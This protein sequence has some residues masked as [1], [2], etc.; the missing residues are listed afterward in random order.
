MLKKFY[1]RMKLIKNQGQGAVTILR[2]GG[3]FILKFCFVVIMRGKPNETR[4][5]KI[6]A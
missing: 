6:E 3:L 1:G 5:N 4:K 2:M